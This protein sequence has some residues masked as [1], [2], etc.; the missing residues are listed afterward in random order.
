MA[1]ER[2]HGGA[3]HEA[4]VTE[5]R[6]MTL[7]EWDRQLSGLSLCEYDREIRRTLR[8]GRLRAAGEVVAGVLALAMLA[9]VAWLFLAATPDQFGAECE[10]LRAEMEAQCE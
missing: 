10:A 8:R 3:I 4:G 2:D 7:E 9:L 6:K 5:G 1:E